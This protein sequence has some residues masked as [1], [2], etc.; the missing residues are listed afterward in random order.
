M[1]DTE[2]WLYE[3]LKH[4][5]KDIIQLILLARIVDKLSDKNDMIREYGDILKQIESENRW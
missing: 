3:E 5:R 1:N 2:N 4:G